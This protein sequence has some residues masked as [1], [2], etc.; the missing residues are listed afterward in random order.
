MASRNELPEEVFAHY[1]LGAERARLSA[2]AGRVERA[3]T[4]EVLARWLPPAPARILDVG[5]GPGTYV[6]W[7]AGQG[8]EV[9]LVDPVPLHVEQ[10]LQAGARTARVADA[11]SIEEPD[12]GFDAVLLLGPLYHL[13]ERSDRVRALS[14]ARRVVREGGLVAAAAISRYASLLDG[15]RT[16]ALDDPAFRSIVERDL[17][18]GQ[19]RNP[20]SKPEWFT[21][22]FFHRPDELQ[23]EVT[24][25]GLRLAELVGL[26]GPA[27]VLGDLDERWGDPEKRERLL[28]AARAVEREPALI[29]LSAHLL[30]VARR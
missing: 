25:A 15:L 11:R 30:A 4:E 19:H 8:Y 9:H 13:T 1:G 22:A 26:E 2:G 21:T 27:W 10:A 7:L 16:G 18:D 20:T 24:D 6:P 3:R 14:E 23:A 5:G 12:A 29:G 17:V 28:S